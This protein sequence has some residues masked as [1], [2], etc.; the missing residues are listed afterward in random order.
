MEERF[1]LRLDLRIVMSVRFNEGDPVVVCDTYREPPARA[2]G[3]KRPV[4]P[5]PPTPDYAVPLPDAW[6]EKL[7]PLPPALHML[8]EKLLHQLRVLQGALTPLLPPP[9]AC[10]EFEGKRLRLS[11]RG[12]THLFVEEMMALEAVAHRCSA[13][14]MP[15][16]V[17]VLTVDV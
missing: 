8:A 10:P 9:V 12:F 1:G 11:V 5:Q 2:G 4:V 6:L 15:S 16:G 14:V 13:V 3:S 7:R 17:L